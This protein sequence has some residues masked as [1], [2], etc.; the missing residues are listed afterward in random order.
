MNM[1]PRKAVGAGVV[2]EEAATQRWGLTGANLVRP[3]PA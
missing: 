1:G 2:L 3:V